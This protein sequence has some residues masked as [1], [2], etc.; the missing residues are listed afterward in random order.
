MPNFQQA[1]APRILKIQWFHLNILIF[2]QKSAFLGPSIFKIPQPNWHYFTCLSTEVKTL[3]DFGIWGFMD[4]VFPFPF[5]LETP[6][7]THVLLSG[8]NS[9]FPGVNCTLQH[10]AR[11]HSMLRADLYTIQL[12]SPS[13][14]P[15]QHESAC[16]V[17]SKSTFLYETKLVIVPFGATF[18]N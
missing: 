2:G 4:L 9:R 14:R 11:C 1:G 7:I 17:W 12:L 8:A 15:P 6:L 10:S 16:P 18:S 5:I 13:D 3:V